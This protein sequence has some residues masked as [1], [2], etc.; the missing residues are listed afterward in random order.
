MPNWCENSVTITGPVDK[1]K[2]LWDSHED[3]DLSLLSAM[4]PIPEGLDGEESYH[5][6]LANWGTKWDINTEGLDFSDLGD[7]L[8]QISGYFESAWAPPVEAYDAFISENSKITIEAFYYEPGMCFCGKW[9]SGDDQYIDDYTDFLSAAAEDRPTGSSV[10]D[11]VDHHFGIVEMWL[12]FCE[13]NDDVA[14]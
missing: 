4:N 14:L 13:Q 2:S 7:G 6:R 11:E 1:L 8:G 10:F 5:W 9:D 3:S 12:D